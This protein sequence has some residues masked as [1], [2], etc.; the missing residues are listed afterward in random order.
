MAFVICILKLAYLA[1]KESDGW[2]CFWPEGVRIAIEL[3]GTMRATIL[4][5][6][7]LDVAKK[8]DLSDRVQAGRHA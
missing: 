4:I 3:S 2:G 8:I 5:C 1:L 6:R 7:A